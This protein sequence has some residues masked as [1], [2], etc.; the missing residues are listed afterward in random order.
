MQRA[1]STGLSCKVLSEIDPDP[2][3][4]EMMLE[5]HPQL[6]YA[7]VTANLCNDG[8]CCF[9]S[10]DVIWDWTWRH[11]T[12]PRRKKLYSPQQS[13]ILYDMIHLCMLHDRA[14]SSAALQTICR[15]D[16]STNLTSVNWISQ[17]PAIT[18]VWEWKTQLDHILT[19]LLWLRQ[20]LAEAQAASTLPRDI[21]IRW[22]DLG[23]LGPM[24][25]MSSN[26]LIVHWA[27]HSEV[28]DLLT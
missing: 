12:F 20:W 9:L 21:W 3:A 11:M 13:F 10:P 5:P 2:N 26:M 22:I 18:T 7:K 27:Q 25:S 28:K 17:I 16:L 4:Q 23:H 8:S 14:C 6:K 1:W 24:S 15:Q 19:R